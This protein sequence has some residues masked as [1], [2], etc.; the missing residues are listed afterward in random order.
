MAPAAGEATLPST[1]MKP[2]VDYATNYD[3]GTD[4][5][6]AIQPVINGEAASQNTFRRPPENLRIRTETQRSVLDELLYFRDK[7]TYQ[8]ACAGSGKLA[9]GG[10]V[11][12]GGDGV[13]NNTTELTISP[14]GGGNANT[15]G[16]IGI[17]TAGTNRVNYTVQ[18]GVYATHGVNRWSVEHR[19]V[20]GQA[21]IQVNIGAGPNYFILV[22]YDDTNNS[23]DAFAVAVAVNLAIAGN[24]GTAGK[25][26]AAG[27]AISSN[28]ID[29]SSGA[30]TFFDGV[31]SATKSG[32]PT[33]D[34]EAHTLPAGA[35][36]TLTTSTP[37]IE[38]AT[39]L[40]AYRDLIEPSG[41]DPDD[42]KTVL[43]GGRAESNPARSNTN[44]V[45]N[46]VILSGAATDGLHLS[47]AIPLVRIVRGVA[48][49]VDGT[50]VAGGYSLAPGAS[51]G[52]E[53]DPSGFSGPTDLE[54]NGGLLTTDDTLEKALLTADKQLARRRVA[55]WTVTN[56]DDS[57]G[58][59]FNTDKGIQ[60]AVTAC[61]DTGGVIHVRRGVYLGPDA[62]LSGPNVTIV[63]EDGTFPEWGFAVN[64][65]VFTGPITFKNM[66]LKRYWGVFVTI[67]GGARFEN[68]IIDTGLFDCQGGSNTEVELIDCTMEQTSQAATPIF[69]LRAH[70]ERLTVRGGKYTGPDSTVA[71]MSA[72][73]N[74][75]LGVFDVLST[76]T[77]VVIEGAHIPDDIRAGWRPV[78]RASSNVNVELL[79]ASIELVNGGRYRSTSDVYTT[80]KLVNLSTS[81][82]T[83]RFGVMRG[84]DAMEPSRMVFHPTLELDLNAA[85]STRVAPGWGTPELE[86]LEVTDPR[87]APVAGYVELPAEVTL[88]NTGSAW[89]AD[90]ADDARGTLARM[91]AGDII[92][93]VDVAFFRV[94]A[95][96][97]DAPN[98]SLLL[99][100]LDSRDLPGEDPPIGTQIARY[101]R[102]I[103]GHIGGLSDATLGVRTWADTE[104]D[105]DFL[106]GTVTAGVE[107]TLK[108]GVVI[109]GELNS[110]GGL[111]VGRIRD[112]LSPTGDT[113]NFTPDFIVARDGVTYARDLFVKAATIATATITTLLGVGSILDVEAALT[114]LITAM[115]TMSAASGEWNYAS[116]L[117]FPVKIM[118]MLGSGYG[119]GLDWSHVYSADVSHAPYWPTVSGDNTDVAHYRIP[120]R[121][122]RGYVLSSLAVTCYGT[123]AVTSGSV[124][125][126]LWRVGSVTAIGSALNIIGNT[127]GTTTISS[128]LPYTVADEELMLTVNLSLADTCDI[129]ITDVATT[130]SIPGPR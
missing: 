1:M 10:T 83:T 121:L 63:G 88:T 68:C 103:R 78:T 90:F 34:I 54:N 117:S 85:P 42:P 20:T 84:D 47:G 93:I 9:W 120:I 55:T 53:F 72:T 32:T 110:G 128:G 108:G 8:L 33:V 62:N 91:T 37:L 109:G 23:H 122:P 13:L 70:T 73:P 7:P 75:R 61:D 39:I 45:A 6:T 17:G 64:D 115:G 79:S 99:H 22:T 58:G 57:V 59:D 40:I 50:A 77:T 65:I 28:V 52:T 38:D 116:P 25:L 104:P 74:T 2:H 126:D 98:G 112:D 49:F 60:D 105:M 76:G 100:G 36:G 51:L 5:V 29:S 69:G 101:Y 102:V 86:L 87:T 107:H 111:V 94:R 119:T 31:V 16:V 35:L 14:L 19:P 97:L 80:G 4:A 129:S 26:A 3:T 41:G 43:A 130:G 46:L 118:A 92:E 27:N 12:N 24:A 44:V 96:N 11:A 30:V 82:E 67:N 114:A 21:S 15:K 123:A 66:R 81:K 48:R 124:Q 127:F 71:A 18:A 95:V 106:D 125:I 89:R 56:N 113:S